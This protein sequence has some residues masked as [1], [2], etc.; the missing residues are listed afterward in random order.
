MQ[1]AQKVGRGVTE[2]I[3]RGVIFGEGEETFW[4]RRVGIEIP[5]H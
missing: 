5:M 3:H 1:G 2:N 4:E